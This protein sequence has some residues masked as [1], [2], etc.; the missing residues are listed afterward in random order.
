MSN[1][2][3]LWIATAAYAVHI[4]EEYQLDWRGWARSVLRLPV[5]W[6]DFYVVNA[7]VIVLGICCAAVGWRRPEFAL[8]LPAV[9]LVN[10]TLFHVVPVIRTGV[11]S[12]GVV[13]AVVLFYPIA[14]WSYYGAWV[15]GVVGVWGCV[16]S[17]IL[18][19]VLMAYPIVLLKVKPLRMFQ[20]AAW[21]PANEPGIP[22]GDAGTIN[23]SRV[24]VGNR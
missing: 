4:L 21:T 12:P 19:T 14:G 20:Y 1:E 9:M 16:A 18:G 24:G 5:E 11:F 8:A 15:D 23:H 10:G 17:G 2:Y 22:A 7:L 13:T 3:V 6:D